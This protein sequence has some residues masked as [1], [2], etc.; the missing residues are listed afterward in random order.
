M[1]LCR[2]NS[3]LLPPNVNPGAIV[4]TWTTESETENLGFI[5]EK[6]IVGANGNSPSSWSQ[7]ASYV[8]DKVL[9]GH[10][11]T[12][13]KHAYQYTDKAVQPGAT[14]LFRLADVDYSGKVKWHKEVEVKVEA[15]AVRIPTQFGLQAIYPNPFNPALT[16]HYG[17]IEDG[18]VSLKVYNLRGELVEVL[19]STYALNG[20]YSVNWQPQNLSAGIYLIRLQSGN[21]TNMQKVVFV[22]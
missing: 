12:S 21:K 1:N 11:S 6:K 22:K 4:L 10:G 18:Q 3:L 8:T 9:T 15:G 20:T 16:I 5:L 17:L 13:A 7:V 19:K 14:Y 2:L